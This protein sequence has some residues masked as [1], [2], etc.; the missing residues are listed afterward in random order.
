MLDYTAY[1]VATIPE[2]RKM[3][4][5]IPTHTPWIEFDLKKYFADS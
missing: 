2:E 1:Q 3:I 4:W 5:R